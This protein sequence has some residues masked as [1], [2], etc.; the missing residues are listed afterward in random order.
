MHPAYS[1]GGHRQEGHH[2]LPRSPHPPPSHSPGCALDARI[3]RPP[4]TTQA[5]TNQPRI[6]SRSSSTGVETTENL[7]AAAPFGGV[8]QSGIGR[9]GGTEG[10]HEYLSTK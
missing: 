2:S 9:E 7:N 4:T 3:R 10:I 5:Q 8:K 1:S 6:A